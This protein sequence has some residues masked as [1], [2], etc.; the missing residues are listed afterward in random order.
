MVIDKFDVV[1]KKLFISEI[2]YSIQGEAHYAGYPCV[3]IRLAGCPLRC[4][5][6]DT[7]YAFASNINLTQQQVIDEVKKYPTKI[8]EVTGGEPLA[9]PKVFS[10]ME[11]LH[12]LDYRVLLETSG[13]MDIS[14]V[15]DFVHVVM[16]IKAPASGEASTN[17]YQN[18]DK[19][20]G[21]DEVKVVIAS[22]EDFVW[23]L[24]KCKT[25]RFFIDYLQRCK[26][27]ILIQ[28][29]FEQLPLEQLSEWVKQYP[30]YFRLGLQWHKYI[31]D[32]QARGV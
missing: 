15:Q 3:F 32:A 6:C 26:K 16:D 8:V 31:Y 1:V 11:K 28:G 5:W 10:L 12:Q 29:A 2:F 22:Q 24:E 14:Q 23:L 20:K 9:Q 27:T 21:S 30:Q 25:N 7:T 17:L 18:L 13:A 4:R 19:L